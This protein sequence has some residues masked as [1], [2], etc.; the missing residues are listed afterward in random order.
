MKNLI[1]TLFFFCFCLSLT[2]QEVESFF[3]SYSPNNIILRIDDHDVIA[4]KDKPNAFILDLP[5]GKH[6]IEAWVEGFEI[7]EYNVEISSAKINSLTIGMKN[8]NSEFETYL[9]AK[10]KYRNNKLKNVVINSAA[11]GLTALLV[12]E[13]TKTFSI[14]NKEKIRLEENLVTAKEDYVRAINDRELA[15]A[16]ASHTSAIHNLENRENYGNAIKGLTV[17]IGAL[18]IFRLIKDKLKKKADSPV[19]KETNPFVFFSDQEN[20]K[21]EVDFNANGISF[22]F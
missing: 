7:Q 13:T 8:L 6:K 16:E 17:G 21:I 5:V 2:A 22:R 14:N 10:R 19:Y 1:L 4:L 11:I 12:V 18:T 9:K 15:I 3:I 20:N